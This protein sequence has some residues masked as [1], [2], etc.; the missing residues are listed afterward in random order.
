MK[1]KRDANSFQNT[2]SATAVKSSPASTAASK[3][4]A[5]IA[6]PRRPRGEF[7]HTSASTAN[8]TTR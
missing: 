7:G 6:W 8:G 1:L 3:A 4:I 2:P 5:L